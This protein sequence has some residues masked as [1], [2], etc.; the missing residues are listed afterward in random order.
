[1]EAGSDLVGDPCVFCPQTCSV[2][3]LYNHKC[4]INK[5]WGLEPGSCTLG[6]KE[7]RPEQSSSN[8]KV[9]K[10]RIGLTKVRVRIEHMAI[11]EVRFRPSW[12]YGCG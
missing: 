6:Q 10:R 8:F 2:C 4:Q 9:L 12:G 1:M 3:Y 11:V 7:K 5:T